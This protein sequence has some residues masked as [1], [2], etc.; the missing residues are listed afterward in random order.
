[1]DLMPGVCHY[2]QMTPDEYKRL[3]LDELKR[4]VA[5]QE[6][7]QRQERDEVEA[8]RYYGG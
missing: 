3:T 5:Y 7:Q 4:L 1:M 8:L 6:K 2:W